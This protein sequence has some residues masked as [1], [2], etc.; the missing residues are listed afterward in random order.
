MRPQFSRWLGAV[1]MDSMV[2]GWRAR[3]CDAIGVEGI[4]TGGKDGMVGGVKVTAEGDE[5]VGKSRL[6]SVEGVDGPYSTGSV[7]SSRIWR[8]QIE[9]PW[10]ASVLELVQGRWRWCERDDAGSLFC[11]AFMLS[12]QVTEP[13][14]CIY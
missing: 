2:S 5:F 10:R 8:P 11:S 7:A 12:T 4:Q 13:G 6:G 14:G 1:W 3:V 9:Q